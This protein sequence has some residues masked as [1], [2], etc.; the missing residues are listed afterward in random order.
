MSPGAFDEGDAVVGGEA[1]A[2]QRESRGP[3]RQLQSHARAD[4]GS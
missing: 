4:D 2:W 1:R 3:G